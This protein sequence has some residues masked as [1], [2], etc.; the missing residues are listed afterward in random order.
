[1]Q[2]RRN[3]VV[4]QHAGMMSRELKTFKN[5]DGSNEI[6]RWIKT[7]TKHGR[8]KVWKTGSVEVIVLGVC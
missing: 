6:L 2:F 4:N 1:M 7:L 8:M 5:N 3:T